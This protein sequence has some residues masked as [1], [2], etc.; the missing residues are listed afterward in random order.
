MA[1]INFRMK[2]FRS[3]STCPGGSVDTLSKICKKSCV[4]LL[5][6]VSTCCPKSANWLFWER[7]LVSTCSESVST[8]Y[9][10]SSNWLFCERDLV[11]T[12]SESVSTWFNVSNLALRKENNS[13]GIEDPPEEV[14]DW[15][16]EEKCGGSKA[17]PLEGELVPLELEAG[18]HDVEAD[19]PDLGFLELEAGP[20]VLGADPLE[21][22]AGPPELEGPQPQL[23][24]F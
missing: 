4:D 1:S 24:L 12:C 18:P 21:P 22:E 11:S 14:D 7:D 10:N 5:L 2:S 15:N 13:G 6:S 19:P 20:L 8:C 17:D 9:P 16:V 3:V 23:A